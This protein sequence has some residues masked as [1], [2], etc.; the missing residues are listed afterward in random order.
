MTQEQE[1][2]CDNLVPLAQIALGSDPTC[3]I[4]AQEC[5]AS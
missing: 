1:M 2:Y 5:A 4:T 3:D